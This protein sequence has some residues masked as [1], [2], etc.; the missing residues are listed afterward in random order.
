M[1]Y[2]DL[3]ADLGLEDDEGRNFTVIPRGAPRPSV[4]STLVAGR[5]KF[6]SWAVI[7]SVEEMANG[8]AIVTFHQVSAKEAASIGPL[9]TGIPTSG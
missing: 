6:W 7:D 9:V 2:I 5:P 8:K 4:G 3:D 1:I